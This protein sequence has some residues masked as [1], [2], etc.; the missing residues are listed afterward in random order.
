M[1]KKIFN[2]MEDLKGKIRVYARVRP[3]LGFE[4]ERGHAFALNVAG[5]SR[6]CV[7]V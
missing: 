5:A 6:A 3:L 7:R 1:R 2:A 4:S